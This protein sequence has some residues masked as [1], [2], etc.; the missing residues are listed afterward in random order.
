MYLWALS[1]SWLS[2]FCLQ[3]IM[4]GER[5]L[6][7]FFQDLPKPLSFTCSLG[8]YDLEGEKKVEGLM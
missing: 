3:E 4:E 8:S 1:K 2:V 6:P 5:N 7:V